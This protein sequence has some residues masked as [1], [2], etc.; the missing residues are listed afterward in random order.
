MFNV[1]D[2]KSQFIFEARRGYWADF[3]DCMHVYLND[4]N[5]TLLIKEDIKNKDGK[6][7]SKAIRIRIDLDK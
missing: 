5:L 3:P 6:W 7:E 4:K 1:K 2:N